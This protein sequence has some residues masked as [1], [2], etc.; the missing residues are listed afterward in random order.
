M[1]QLRIEE[2]T[3]A[4]LSGMQETVAD[5]ILRYSEFDPEFE[6]D[7]PLDRDNLI[8]HNVRARGDYIM[9]LEESIGTTRLQMELLKLGCEGV[10]R[11][12]GV[13]SETEY[14]IEL[15]GSPLRRQGIFADDEEVRVRR[16][17][18][19]SDE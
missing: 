11:L 13:K 15:C 17:K 3:D 7:G 18:L 8:E 16:R 12:R 9:R 1:T 5:E 10:A 6:P 2:E 14:T 19:D 4:Y